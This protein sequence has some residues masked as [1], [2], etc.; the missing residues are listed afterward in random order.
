MG[1]GW[2][3]WKTIVSAHF[4]DEETSN[5]IGKGQQVGLFTGKPKAKKDTET[6]D[7]PKLFLGLF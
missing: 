3:I 2:Q 6:G 7:E 1:A 5:A 4:Q